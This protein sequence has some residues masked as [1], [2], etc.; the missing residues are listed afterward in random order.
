MMR[1]ASRYWFKKL[2]G[3]MLWI[4]GL[5]MIIVYSPIGYRAL[6]LADG[7]NIAG[8]LRFCIRTATV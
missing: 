3:P 2:L 8:F 1:S 6:N 7:E 5:V 4:A